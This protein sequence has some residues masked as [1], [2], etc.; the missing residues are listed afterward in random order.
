M[1]DKVEERRLLRTR[2]KRATMP[3]TEDCIDCKDED[4]AHI[5]LMKKRRGK[6]T[7]VGTE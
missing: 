6:H 7:H 1:I 4:K 5:E 2:S 3:E